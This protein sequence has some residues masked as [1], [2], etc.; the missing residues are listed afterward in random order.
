MQAEEEKKCTNMR[1]VV[2]ENEEVEKEE[3]LEPPSLFVDAIWHAHMQLSNYCCD[4]VR[5]SGSVVDHKF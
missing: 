5:I 3:D 1:E 2:K 4:S